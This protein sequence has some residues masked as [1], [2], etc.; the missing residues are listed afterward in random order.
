VARISA[1]DPIADPAH[2][3]NGI[4]G[5]FVELGQRLQRADP[6]RSPEPRAKANLQISLAHPF[7]AHGEARCFV[8]YRDGKAIGRV[9]AIANE[10]ALDSDDNGRQIGYLG[11]YELAVDDHTVARELLDAGCD[12]LR[13]LCDVRRVVGP[14][15]FSTWYSYRLSDPASHSASPPLWLE[16][17]TPDAYP[18]Q[19]VAAGFLPVLGYCSMQFDAVDQ[20]RS[21]KVDALH[22]AGYRMRE[23]DLDNWEGELQTLFELS[24]A[25]FADNIHYTPI[26]WE[27]FRPMYDGLERI[28]D[29][30]LVRIAVA[31]DGSDAGFLFATPNYARS[32]LAMNGR[33]S[34]WGKLAFKR[35]MG[36]ADGILLKT[37]TSL[38][39]HRSVG[40]GGA[41]TW[42]AVQ[43]G[44]KLGYD[45]MIW[46][47][48]YDDNHTRAMADAALATI[49]R[50]YNLYE[51]SL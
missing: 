49:A 32:A 37:I 21:S 42:E 44:Q 2:A 13:E 41:L 15:N 27:E 20:P 1:F 3:S 50:R 4:A 9:M 22:D 6:Y 31:P 45:R 48:M 43:A 19:W 33:S 47:L 10:H 23:V 34:L 39:E 24:L 8:A 12:W 17:R 40:L 18:A 11:F 7:F 38:A 36:A 26:E 5:D 16:P 29:P 51:R 28:A 25:G 14:M 35:N 46:M 30:R